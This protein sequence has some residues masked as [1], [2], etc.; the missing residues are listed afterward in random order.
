LADEDAGPV[1]GVAIIRASWWGTA[2]TCVAVVLNAVTGDRDNYLL[3]AVPALVLFVTG[4]AAFLWAF[5]IAVG[6]SRTEVI[7][8]GQLFFLSGCAPRRVQVSMMASL[9]VQSVVPL[10]VAVIRPFT[11]FGV[12]APM[13]ALG[14]AGLWGARHGRFPARPGEPGQEDHENETNCGPDDPRTEARTHG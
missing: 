2:V 7:G 5:S 11:A 1:P 9:A 14:L 4:C 8:V 6:R 12:L 3:S 10:I 13:W